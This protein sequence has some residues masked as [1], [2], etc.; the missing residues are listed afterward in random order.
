M[1]ES[2]GFSR[3]VIAGAEDGFESC[4]ERVRIKV[5]N[6]KDVRSAGMGWGPD[7][8]DYIVR[9]REYMNSVSGNE[10][11]I[12]DDSLSFKYTD[13]GLRISLSGD[14]GIGIDKLAKEITDDE[15]SGIIWKMS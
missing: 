1:A 4:E 13:G 6:A 3:L 8:Y 9:N 15:G 10:V 2:G 12:A 5:I 14:F 7:E 11:S